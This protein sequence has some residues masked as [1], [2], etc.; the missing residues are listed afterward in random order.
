VE[1]AAFGSPHLPLFGD[2]LDL[3]FFN[4][5]GCH[6]LK[7][8]QQPLVSP[9]Q[10]R[11]SMQPLADGFLRQTGN[12]HGT[13]QDGRRHNKMGVGAMEGPAWGGGPLLR[14]RQCLGAAAYIATKREDSGTNVP[15]GRTNGRTGP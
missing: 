15:N 9:I 1:A 13:G 5:H 8:R 10:E 14:R 4:L 2:S 3:L 7:H 6:R 12:H 11:Q